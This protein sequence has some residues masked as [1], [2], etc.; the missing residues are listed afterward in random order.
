MSISLQSNR[1]RARHARREVM[2][3]IRVV[4]SGFQVNRI[5]VGTNVQ[6]LDDFSDLSR[7]DSDSSS[8]ASG[9]I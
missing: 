4:E 9:N 1:R 6:S 2:Q 7:D 3:E 8:T 5:P